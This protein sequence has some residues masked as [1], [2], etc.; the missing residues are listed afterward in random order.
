[1]KSLQDPYNLADRQRVQDWQGIWIWRI[2]MED[3]LLAFAVWGI[4]AEIEARARVWDKI[5]ARDLS[6]G[7]RSGKFIY[8][9]VH[10]KK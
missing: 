3:I 10:P 6:G 5:L 2:R 9:P 7:I 4:K 1:M 8:F